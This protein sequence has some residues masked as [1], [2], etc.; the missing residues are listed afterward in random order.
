M[1]GDESIKNF[2]ENSSLIEVLLV[3]SPRAKH[4]CCA[5]RGHS[6]VRNATVTLFLWLGKQ[7]KM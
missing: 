4:A 3:S 7:K 5:L 6:L 2:R 1:I